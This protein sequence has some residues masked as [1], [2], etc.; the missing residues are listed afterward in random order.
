VRRI[1]TPTTGTSSRHGAPV[2]QVDRIVLEVG[3]RPHRRDRAHRLLGAAGRGPPARPLELQARKLLRHRARGHAERLQGLRAQV[4]A[5]LAVYAA[6][7]RDGADSA[8]AVDRLGHHVVDEPRQFVGREPVGLHGVGQQRAADQAQPCDVR[9]VDVVRQLHAH[10]R[11]RIAHLIEGRVEIATEFELDP[12]DR[13]AFAD[14]GVDLVDIGDARDGVLDLAGDVGLELRGRGARQRDA[15]LDRRQ[16]DV[17]ELRDRQL[18][19]APQAGDAQQHECQHRR[20]RMAD[21]PERK[22][23]GL[24]LPGRP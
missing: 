1:D 22:V 16:R 19:Q 20:Q 17:R 5:D 4:D 24:R 2:R 15:H 12:G 7:A 3:R 21:T 23:H 18:P 10:A 9:L 14:G 13:L 8:D 11:H 6:R